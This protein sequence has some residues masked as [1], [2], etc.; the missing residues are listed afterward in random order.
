MNLWSRLN[1]VSADLSYST[2]CSRVLLLH[3]AQTHVYCLAAWLPAHVDWTTRC[4]PHGR[5]RS[6]ASRPVVRVCVSC[7]PWE[8]KP[9]G[10][11]E[12][13]SE[14]ED[15]GLVWPAAPPARSPAR[16]LRRP[17]S[18]L[19]VTGRLHTHTRLGRITI[20]LGSISHSNYYHH[21]FWLDPCVLLSSLSLFL[22][23]PTASHQNAA[24]R[25]E[26]PT[27]PRPPGA[28]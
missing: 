11:S 10:M 22:S 18:S 27:I 7:W 23:N 20:E 3:D 5:R 4:P 19:A 25:S 12:W 17:S 9:E 16:R 26:G 2:G 28:I 13:V 6:F 8:S 14:R 24:N 15:P 21:S 1:P